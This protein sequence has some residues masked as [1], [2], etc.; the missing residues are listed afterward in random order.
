MT[1]ATATPSEQL[2]TRDNCAVTFIDHQPEMVLGV[3]SIDTT[4]LKNNTV[5]L[6]KTVDAYDIPTVLSTIGKEHNRPL[7]EEIRDVFPDEEAIDR[8]T[9]NSWENE[10]Y[11]EAIEATDRDRIVMAGLWTEVCVCFA[12]LSALELL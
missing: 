2:L 3:N 9:L 6:A 1:N 10:A 12:A 11:V 7:F 4:N 5:G 8:T